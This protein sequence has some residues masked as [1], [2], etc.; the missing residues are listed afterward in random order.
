VVKPAEQE[1]QAKSAPAKS[2]AVIG[3]AKVYQGSKMVEREITIGG[4]NNQSVY[5]SNIYHFRM[6]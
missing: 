4:G 2:P 6:H 1:L 5:Q 3:K